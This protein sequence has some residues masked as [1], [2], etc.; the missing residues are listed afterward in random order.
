M[1]RQLVAIAYIL[2]VLDNIDRIISAGFYLTSV[3]LDA[4]PGVLDDKLSFKP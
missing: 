4:L 1:M 3:A 2:G